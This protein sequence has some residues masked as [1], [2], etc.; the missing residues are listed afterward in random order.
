[1]YKTTDYTLVNGRNTHKTANKT[2][3]FR[4]LSFIFSGV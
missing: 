2:E 1:M 4:S 3:F